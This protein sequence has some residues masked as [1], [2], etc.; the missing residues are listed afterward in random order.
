MANEPKNKPTQ[1]EAGDPLFNLKHAEAE[2]ALGTNTS[3]INEAINED[4]PEDDDLDEGPRDSQGNRRGE[5]DPADGTAA[6]SH[7]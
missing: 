4:G 6:G 7:K 2:A 1:P 5:N 3:A